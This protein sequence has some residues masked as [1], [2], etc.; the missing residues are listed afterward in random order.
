MR[1]RRF[2]TAFVEVQDDE[3]G[4]IQ[5]QDNTVWLVLP[6]GSRVQLPSGGSQGPTGATGPAG[7]EGATGERGPIGV[8]GDAGARGPTGPTGAT[9]AGVTGPTGSVGPTG[10]EGPTGPT[11]ATGS[12]GSQGAQGERGE[13]GATGPTGNQGV[14][15][16][17]GS[18]GSVG[19][20][21]PTGATGPS[22]LTNGAL[23]SAPPASSSHS[24]V[25]GTAYQNTLGYDILLVVFLSV[26]LNTSGVV[27]LGV[28]PTNT[29]TQQTISSGV[30][31]VGFLSVP[32]YIPAGYYALLSV[33]GTITDSI[34]GQIAMPV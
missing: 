13:V 10:A 20:T 33:S 16:P 17:T 1:E 6:D 23:V 26:T 18:M 7:S 19:A 29:P 5:E 11:G 28:G 27:K 15:G 9:G 22:P 14:T 25:L 31:T 30:S 24:L 34:A 12:G 4:L 2:Q 3:P 21:G 32:I 8:T